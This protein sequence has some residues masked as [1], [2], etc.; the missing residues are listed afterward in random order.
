M[1]E[2]SQT[3]SARNAII[4]VFV[5]FALGLLAIG[6]LANRRWRAEHAA[7]KPPQQTRP[8]AIDL[9]PTNLMVW[10]KCYS[11]EFSIPSD[12]TNAI[13]AGE[14]TVEPR[15]QAQL[16]MLVVTSA[17]FAHWQEF[18][19]PRRPK[20]Q[21]GRWRLALPQRQYGGGAARNQTRARHLRADFR[22]R[23]AVGSNVQRTTTAALV[24]LRVELRRH[25][26]ITLSYDLP[27]EIR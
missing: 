5:A 25:T 12:A 27:Q 26:K 24:L 3:R 17:G 15:I 4:S 6:L 1:T 2:N 8:V 16:N 20:R 13:L 18:F 11:H 19:F 7:R 9:L 23:S 21:C 14:F 10:N 22:L